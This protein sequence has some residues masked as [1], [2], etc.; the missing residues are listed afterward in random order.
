[1]RRTNSSGMQ[2]GQDNLAITSTKFLK[3]YSKILYPNEV[4]LKKKRQNLQKPTH[5]KMNA[6]FFIKQNLIIDSVRNPENPLNDL[7]NS[8]GGENKFNFF[9]FIQERDH[10]NRLIQ[11]NVKKK[12]EKKLIFFRE[13]LFP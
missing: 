9:P 3:S 4:K 10:L 11:R 13:F 7:L 6:T 1:M 8:K 12:I 2:T 5:N